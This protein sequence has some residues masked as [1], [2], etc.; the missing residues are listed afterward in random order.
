MNEV[1]WFPFVF[2]NQS[3]TI[4]LREI[5]NINNLFS[6]PLLSKQDGFQGLT[7]SNVVMILF[8]KF[9]HYSRTERYFYLIISWFA[10]CSCRK[11][12]KELNIWVKRF[13]RNQWKNLRVFMFCINCH[14]VTALNKIYTISPTYPQQH[15]IHSII[16][17]SNWGNS[18][19]CLHT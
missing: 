18:L 14:M 4:Y 11:V 12:L 17:C 5:S 7:N 16:F 2:T 3:C 10:M 1:T 9:L 8:R 6:S 19:T 15:T 13:E